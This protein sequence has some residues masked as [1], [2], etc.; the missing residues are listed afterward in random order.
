M[1]ITLF[2]AP[3]DPHPDLF[4][5]GDDI[6]WP[7]SIKPTPAHAPHPGR[8]TLACGCVVSGYLSPLD[9]LPSGATVRHCGQQGPRSIH[10]AASPLPASPG[11]GVG[12]VAGLLGDEP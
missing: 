5:W 1:Q 11:G 7:A 12:E 9:G 6:P 2:A 3:A 4:P 8:Y 10:S